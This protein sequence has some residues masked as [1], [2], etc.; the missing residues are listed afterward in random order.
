M[1]ITTVDQSRTERIEI[2]SP[3]GVRD[4]S[5]PVELSS[6]R[7]IDIYRKMTE[8]RLFDER[9]VKLQ[10]QGRLGTYPM[11]LGQEATQIVPPLCLRPKDWL[12]PTYR[13]QGAYYA[14]GMQLRYSLLYWAGDD[15]GVHFPQENND[16]IFAI[17]VGSHL[18]Q[19]AGLAWAEKLR[20]EGGVAM[21]YLGD[22]TSSKGDLH[23]A[24]TFCAAMALPMI[25]IIENNHWAISVPR[26]K[27]SAGK[28]LAQK[29]RGYGIYGVQTDGNDVLAVHKAVSEAV[30]RA[31]SGGGPS[32]I[33]CET[34]RLS[35][36]TTA[37]DAGRYRD[38]AEVNRWKSKDPLSRLRRYLESQKIWD[39]KR[40]ESLLRDAAAMLE[41]E[42]KA[43]ESFPPPNPLNMFSENYASAT[44][45]LIEQRGEL[46]RI[47]KT[48]PGE[49][50]LTVLPPVE[51]RFP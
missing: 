21:A 47:L 46:E 2:L 32:L 34:Y 19:A 30:E 50:N 35:H 6:E 20:G 9:C 51:G 3:E 17:P 45:A 8:I 39:A 13:G 28:T 10:R 11:I 23:E 24:L 26:E 14:R 22:G 36:H 25:C 33:E 15:R 40:E 18:T 49:E 38:Q 41:L 44:P 29:A 48:K 5:I 27:Q 12:V 4:F 16:L 43:Y 31:R 7:L 37:D 1:P 42:I